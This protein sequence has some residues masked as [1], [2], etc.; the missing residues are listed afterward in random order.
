MNALTNIRTVE[1]ARN[2]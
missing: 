2:L 1:R